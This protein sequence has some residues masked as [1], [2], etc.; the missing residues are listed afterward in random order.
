MR[1]AVVI[2]NSN[3]W[4]DTIECLESV[5]RS[6]LPG[7]SAIVCDNASHDGSAARLEAWAEGRLEAFVPASNPLRPLSWPPLPKP[8]AHACYERAEAERGGDPEVDPP[9]VLVRNEENLGF[10]GGNNVGL[11][12]VIA[13]GDFDYVW[14]LNPDTVV[15]PDS[16]RHLVE[17]MEADPAMGACGSTVLYYGAPDTVQVLGGARYNR[18][19]ALPN[20]IGLG[21][22][23]A[24]PVDA[25]DVARGMTYVYGASM[26]VSRGFLEDVGLLDEDYFLYF[27]ELDWAMRAR[28]RYGLGFAPR[29]VVYH[30]EGTKLGAGR[31]KSFVSD[32]YFM[33]NR[34]RVTRKY[35][36]RVLPT[37]YVALAAALLRRAQRGQWDRV[38]M[39]AKLMVSE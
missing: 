6:D 5:L 16:L 39:I 1:V 36:P 15:R 26:L 14:L 2:V 20:H 9:L 4:T 27:E 31:N 22:P 8:V 3:S 13:R 28:G 29:S 7:V 18:W 21:R 19:L 12:Y 33:R 10:A 24:A 23:A 34:I 30:R 37:V 32:F 25:A 17:A 38:R 35:N 11:R